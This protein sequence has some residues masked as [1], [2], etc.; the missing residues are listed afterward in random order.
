MMRFESH[1]HYLMSMAPMAPANYLTFPFF[2]FIYLEILTNLE[3]RV[4]CDK[5]HHVI[6]PGRHRCASFYLALF[7][8]FLNLWL[9]NALEIRFV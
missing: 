7:V 6:P 8:L 4:F 9:Q 2:H 1:L 3:D 5:L